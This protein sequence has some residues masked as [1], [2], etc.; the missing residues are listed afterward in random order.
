MIY[1]LLSSGLRLD[2]QV[3]IIYPE[4]RSR[5]AG[6]PAV[7]SS[8]SFLETLRS[9]LHV[10]EAACGRCPPVPQRVGVQQ[11]P[12]TS[13]LSD[14][15]TTTPSTRRPGSQTSAGAGSSFLRHSSQPWGPGRSS[16]VQFL[17]SSAS[18]LLLSSQSPVISS[19]CYS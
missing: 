19:L 3:I 17:Y 6:Q 7:S 14:F 11:V 18:S 5:T 4:T 8:R 10:L 13:A 2:I 15:S 9:Q 16:C 12:P 1:F